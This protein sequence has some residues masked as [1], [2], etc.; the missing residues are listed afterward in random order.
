MNY[1]FL[2]YDSINVPH[3][4]YLLNKEIKDKNYQ[5]ISFALTKSRNNNNHMDIDI[6]VLVS[7]NPRYYGTDVIAE[8]VQLNRDLFSCVLQDN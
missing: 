2:Y 8:K 6:V 1:L 3:N 4:L 5:V 7:T